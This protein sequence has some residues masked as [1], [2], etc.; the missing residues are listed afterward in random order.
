MQNTSVNCRV[1]EGVQCYGEKTFQKTDVPCVRCIAYPV[2]TADNLSGVCC[3]YNCVHSQVQWLLLS[4]HNPLLGV[5]GVPWCGPVLSW[6]H[7]PW[8]GQAPD[9][10]RIGGV[11]G[12]GHH[13]AT[14]RTDQ[15]SRRLQ[16]GTVLLAVSNCLSCFRKYLCNKIMYVVSHSH[17]ISTHSDVTM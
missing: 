16:L 14:G 11:V 15:P 17:S 5:P 7:M 4:K 2:I 3:K 8:G 13:L 6:A 10:G 1:L 9:T 12:G